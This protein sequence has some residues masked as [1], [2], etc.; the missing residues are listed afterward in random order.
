MR[1]GRRLQ[2]DRVHAGD[3]DQAALQQVDDFQNALRERVG[4][5][6]MR[7][8]QALDARDRLVDARVVLHRAGAERI[9]AEI[10]GVVPCGEPREVADDLDLAELRKQARASCDAR[11]QAGLRHQQQAH[12]AAA[13]CRRACRARTSRRAGPRS[14]SGEGGLCRWSWSGFHS[15]ASRFPLP[16]AADSLAIKCSNRHSLCNKGTALA[17]PKR[18]QTGLGFKPLLRARLMALLPLGF[19]CIVRF[20]PCQL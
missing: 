11:R 1:A 4:A 7:L 15:I 8:G 14:A 6:G 12:R 10:D 3:L 20:L 9:H 2:R 5:V 16:S 19:A 17:V 13:T 18:R